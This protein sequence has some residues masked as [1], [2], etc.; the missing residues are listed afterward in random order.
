M[1]NCHRA[2]YQSYKSNVA[3]AERTSSIDYKSIE[4]SWGL[5]HY[6]FLNNS[7][8]IF[9]GVHYIY[10]IPLRSTYKTNSTTLKI[11]STSNAAFAVGYKYKTKC[12]IELKYNLSRNLLSNYVFWSADYKTTSV[13]FSYTVF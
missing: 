7:S 6:F 11:K 5:R 13:V 2:V 9:L 10:D 4:S 3:T 1:G 12:S 8:R